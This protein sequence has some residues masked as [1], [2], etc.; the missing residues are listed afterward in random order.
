MSVA[1]EF[2]LSNSSLQPAQPQY[3]IVVPAYNERARIGATLEQILE[4]DTWAR[5]A[6]SL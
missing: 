5:K 4:A 2:P 6:T 3:S 1:L